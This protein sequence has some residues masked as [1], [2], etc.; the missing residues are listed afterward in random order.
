MHYCSVTQKAKEWSTNKYL[1]F[2]NSLLAQPLKKVDAGQKY[3]EEIAK[4]PHESKEKLV[5]SL[6]GLLCN[7]EKHWPDDELHRRAPMWSERLSS[8]NVNITD[9]GYGSRFVFYGVSQ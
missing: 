3:F 8:I 9:F 4:Q 7:P 2:G 1:G 5:Q 6:M